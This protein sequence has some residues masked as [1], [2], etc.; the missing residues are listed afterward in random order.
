MFLEQRFKKMKIIF[1]AYFFIFKTKHFSF[2]AQMIRIVFINDLKGR[3]VPLMEF[4]FPNVN[5]QIENWSSNVSDFLVL[6]KSLIIF[7]QSYLEIFLI[8]L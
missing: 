3:N 7:S 2:D 5:F 6:F 4:V 1:L 8:L